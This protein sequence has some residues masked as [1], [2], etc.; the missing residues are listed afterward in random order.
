MRV[1]DD[2]GDH[3][4]LPKCWAASGDLRCG[5]GASRSRVPGL[6][7]RSNGHP[8]RLNV[9][10]IFLGRW[11]RLRSQLWKMEH[12]STRSGLE[13]DYFL[14]QC[15]REHQPSHRAQCTDPLRE[16]PQTEYA[17]PTI[18]YLSGSRLGSQNFLL[19]EVRYVPE[20][21]SSRLPA[22]SLF[23]VT[24]PFR[25]EAESTPVSNNVGITCLKLGVCTFAHRFGACCFSR[26]CERSSNGIVILA[27]HCNRQ[28]AP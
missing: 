8:G 5:F 4:S 10:D 9:V 1:R 3:A 28:S 13:G 24:S 27:S 15:R 7:C 17:N 12:R 23:R 20:Q 16:C 11:V 21:R 14:P 2:H 26:C 22:A 25:T 6:R 19:L 18:L